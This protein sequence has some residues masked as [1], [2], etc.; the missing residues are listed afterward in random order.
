MQPFTYERPASLDAAFAFAA[1]PGAMLLAGGTTMV[2][3][4]SGDLSGPS[5]VVDIGHLDG[6]S[7]IEATP[8]GLRLGALARMAD[9]AEH[10]L[11]QHGHPAL[12]ESLQL[13]ASQQLR[14][15]ATL[16]GNLL[17]RT[18]CVYYRDAVSACNKRAPGS[19]CAAQDGITRD[20]AIFGGSDRCI[21]TYP[22]DWA[23]AL[24]AFDTIVELRSAAGTRTIP[25]AELHVPY[26][27]DPA[28][29]T[30]LRP[31]EIITAILVAATPAARAST[32]VKLRDRRSYAYAVVSAAVAL[33]MDGDTVREARVSLGGVADRPWR[34]LEAEAA[35]AGQRLSHDIAM[36]AG[37]AAMAPARTRP[38]NDFKRELGA[39]VIARA[40]LTAAARI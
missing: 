11:L 30:H 25:F 17:Q 2:D 8:H 32:Y 33:D 15:A 6:L 28:A 5:L 18:R 10:P 19:G 40:V 39:R 9:A 36:A 13:A 35:L 29:E 26:G 34:S 21:A 27:E 22:G 1:R 3:V 14:N 20:M 23:T 31:G 37:H 38:D 24:A 12:A 7:A 16:G 4:M